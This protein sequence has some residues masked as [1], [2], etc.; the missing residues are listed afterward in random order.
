MKTMSLNN[1]MSITYKGSYNYYLER[2]QC[3]FCVD[4]RVFSDNGEGKHSKAET[5]KTITEISLDSAPVI[6]TV[7]N[8]LGFRENVALKL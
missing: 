8:K 7:L 1:E 4:M 5:I 3:W 2:K 6:A